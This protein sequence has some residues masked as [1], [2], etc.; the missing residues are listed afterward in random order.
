MQCAE[1]E[2]AVRS[3]VAAY[4]DAVNRRD[5]EGMAAV[6]IAD[7]VIEKPGFGDPVRGVE[8]ILKRY[9]R[10]QRERDFLCQLINSGIVE[11][12]GD[13][14]TARWWFTEVKKPV[15]S[16]DWLYLIGVYQDESVRTPDGWRLARRVQTTILD[17]TIPS[18]SGMVAN[19]LPAFFPLTGLP[20]T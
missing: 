20:T 8:K 4:T 15:G 14:A 11:V 10:L 19:A 7:G 5:A 12:N 2:L 17:Q 6:F 13:K 18:G 3:L 1:D 16:D 9:R